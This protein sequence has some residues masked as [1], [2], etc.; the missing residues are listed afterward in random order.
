MLKN[1]FCIRAFLD[2]SK[3][4]NSIDHTKLQK[5]STIMK[6]EEW[7]WIV[8]KPSVAQT[9][10]VSYNDEYSTQREIVFGV[11]QGSVLGQLLFIIYSNDCPNSLKTCNC[12]LF[13][14]DTTIYQSH[15]TINILQKLVLRSTDFLDLDNPREQVTSEHTF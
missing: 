8:Q 7:P 14:D 9:A 15:H 4:F 12:I 1:T 5:K 11:P 13:A 3:A 6:L 2:L 10:F